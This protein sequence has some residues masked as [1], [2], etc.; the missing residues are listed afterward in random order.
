MTACAHA[1]SP[2]LCVRT[3]FLVPV[4]Q[5][6][7]AHVNVPGFRLEGLLPVPCSASVR[8]CGSDGG[9]A[10]CL[11]ESDVSLAEVAPRVA[12]ASGPYGPS[13]PYAFQQASFWQ[14]HTRRQ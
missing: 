5:A 1:C 2:D 9:P 12:H 13:L 11:A 4:S 6:A 10:S 7:A 3:C 14:I 8:V